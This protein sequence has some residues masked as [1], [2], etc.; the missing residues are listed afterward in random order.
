MY[1]SGFGQCCGASIL[2]GFGS[3]GAPSSCNPSKESILRFLDSKDVEMR[4]KSNSFVFTIL[5]DKVFQKHKD[6][7]FDRG[8]KEIACLPNVAH[9]PY[10]ILHVLLWQNEKAVSV[11][12]NWLE[13]QN[14]MMKVLESK[15]KKD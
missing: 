8:F 10:V 5:V 13:A 6:V 11:R 15:R 7:F 3:E 14:Q 12:E 2:Y 1:I 9:S 4:V